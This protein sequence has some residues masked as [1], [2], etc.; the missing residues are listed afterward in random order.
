[1]SVKQT[2]YFVPFVYTVLYFAVL[3]SVVPISA[4]VNQK[5]PPSRVKEVPMHQRAALL[6]EDFSNPNRMSAL[7]TFWQTFTD[8]VMGGVST[9]TSR[10]ETTDGR[11]ALRLVGDVSL[12]NNGGFIQVA[13]P[14]TISGANLDASAY[15]GIRLT[16]KGNGETYHVHL[17]TTGTALP[18]QYYHAAFLAGPA[19]ATIDLPF[20]EFKAAA[21][22]SKLDPTQLTRVAVV[23][24]EK[25]F[26]ADAAIAR[27]EFYR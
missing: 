25:A 7:G 21:S 5:R 10:M 20:G 4:A 6:I 1:M 16:V 13:L 2:R 23:A 15:R 18:W 14:L 12:K 26:R 19:W 22:E 24:S 27:I 8:Q 9:A 3:M 11:L 17:R